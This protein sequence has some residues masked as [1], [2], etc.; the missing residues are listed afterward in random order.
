MLAAFRLLRRLAQKV[1]VSSK[2]IKELI[3]QI[4]SVGNN[5]YSWIVKVLYQFSS[6]KN[7]RKGFSGS[8]S[9]PYN[10][11][12]FATTSFRRFNSAFYSL[13]N[14]IILVISSDFLDCFNFYYLCLFVLGSALF[15]GYK[16]TNIVEQGFL[17]A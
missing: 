12:F 11:G 15:K 10:T 17:I 9:M 7:H 1:A 4:I 6:I 13:I 5:N 3:V 8:L 2:S 14:R 16:I